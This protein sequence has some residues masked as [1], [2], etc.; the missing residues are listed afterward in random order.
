MRFHSLVLSILN[1]VPAVPI[2]YGHK[3]VSLAEKCGLNDYMVVWNSYQSEYF[4]ESIDISS[5]EILKKV[6][7]LCSN[8]DSVKTEMVK[9]KCGLIKS[10]SDAFVQL[11][12]VLY[13]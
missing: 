11:E 6:D 7:L 9:N 3:T 2:A 4:G 10:A 5:S 8:I 1:D 12:K 13:K